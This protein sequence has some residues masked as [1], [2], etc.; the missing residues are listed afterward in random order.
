T[1][2]ACE[3]K[4]ANTE[5]REPDL[6]DTGAVRSWGEEL[7][8]DPPD[9]LVANAG[10]NTNIDKTPDGEP[11]EETEDC[12]K[13]NLLS[14]MALTGALIPAFRARHRGQIAI[15]SSLAAYYGLAHTPAYCAT[16]GALKNWGASLRGWLAP[17]GILVSVVFPGYVRSPMCDAMPGPK[18]FLWEPEKAAKY[19]RAGLERDQGRISFPFP[20]N[21][22]IWALSCLPLFIAMPIARLL[23]YGK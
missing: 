9:L 19:I 3:K 5:L 20:L 11:W 13:I 12:V 1:A 16:K 17:E 18:P 15:V 21:L 2:A 8:L 23:G 6:R 10:M 14:V 22:G 4:G 7:S